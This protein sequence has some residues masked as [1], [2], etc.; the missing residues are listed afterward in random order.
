MKNVL[1]SIKTWASMKNTIT[2]ISN[3]K[4]AIWNLKYE[5]LIFFYLFYL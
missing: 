3:N 5:K 2:Q 1:F 4:I